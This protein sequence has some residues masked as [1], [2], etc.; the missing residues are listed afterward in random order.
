MTEMTAPDRVDL[1]FDPQ[2]PFTWR[3]SRWLTEVAAERGM[4]VDWHVMSLAVLNAGKDAPEHVLRRRAQGLVT[5]RLFAAVRE[6]HG[7]DALAR[8][9]TEFG[10]RMHEQGREPGAELYREAL[11]AV[12]LPGELT[13]AGVGETHQA[14]LEASHAAG[15]ERV[16]TEAGSPV[17]AFDGRRGFFGPIV[18]PAPTG[19]AALRLLDGLALVTA[20]PGFSELKGARGAP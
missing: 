2:C 18:V 19:D 8:L 11:T 9:Y 3:T 12:G 14:A 16:G 15:Q 13:D 20:V 7:G 6:A 10:S 4:R 17:L 5:G 1:W